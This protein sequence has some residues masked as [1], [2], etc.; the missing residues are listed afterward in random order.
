MS[1]HREKIAHS[2]NQPRKSQTYPECPGHRS[3][4]PLGLPFSLSPSCNCSLL[5]FPA[6]YQMEPLASCIGG[7]CMNFGCHLCAGATLISIVPI[8]VY[9]L[10]K[11]ALMYNFWIQ[12]LDS[13]TAGQ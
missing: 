9:V 11:R 8:L 6:E 4:V 13:F 10:P 2:Q 1:A 5:G 7:T 12:Y 3:S